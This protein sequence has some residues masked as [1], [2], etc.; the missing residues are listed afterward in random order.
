MR[1]LADLIAASTPR[2]GGFPLSLPGA[3][4]VRQS[5][6]SPE[7]VH[8]TLGP[9][10]CVAAQGAKAV[11]LGPQMF[12]YDPSHLLL[13]SVGLPISAQVMRASRKDPYLGFVLDLNPTRIAELAGRAFPQGIPRAS[14]S[15]GLFVG[16]PSEGLIDAVT[17]LIRLTTQER[18]DANLLGP[19]LVDE[20]LLRLLRSPVGPR[21]AQIGHARSEVQRVATAITWLRGH[22]AQPI[23]V[24]EIAASARMSAST[25]H[26]HFKAVTS[27]SPIQYQKVLR[28]HE[29]RRLMLF[30]AADAGSAAE[31]VGYLSPSQFSREYARYFGN[32]P[33]KDVTH[34]RSAGFAI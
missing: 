8:A 20:I 10:L 18:E 30:H 27:M 2:D 31:R 5:H 22:F 12:R 13:F 32:P 16:R 1:Q 19:L 29:A 17:R 34:L 23:T 24:D 11:M 33:I 4:L 6:P 15:R 21:V 28:L 3:H 14:E 26:Q 7:A 25:F 9:A